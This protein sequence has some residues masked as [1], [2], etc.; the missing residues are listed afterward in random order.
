MGHAALVLVD[1]LAGALRHRP[2][3]ALGAGGQADLLVA[4]LFQLRQ[5]VGGVADAQLKRFDLALAGTHRVL[6]PGVEPLQLLVPLGLPLRLL[7]GRHR[8]AAARL[9]FRG[10]RRLAAQHAAVMVEHLVAGV[11]GLLVERGAHRQGAVRLGVA[12]HHLTG[13]LILLGR[14]RRQYRQ[15]QQRQHQPPRQPPH[16][17]PS[18]P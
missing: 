2:A 1:G 3:G 4:L 13:G 8:L 11:D 16:G 14:R 6:G 15:R 17:Y 7:L 5:G 9:L 10:R 18:T 12:V